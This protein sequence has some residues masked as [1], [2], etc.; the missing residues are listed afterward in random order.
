MFQWELQDSTALWSLADAELIKPRN[1][2][3]RESKYESQDQNNSTD[4]KKEKIAAKLSAKL[5]Q[6]SC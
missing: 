3:Q 2:G 1:R 5:R 4:Q 6:A